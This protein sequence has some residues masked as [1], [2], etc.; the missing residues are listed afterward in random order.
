VYVIAAL[1]KVI[2]R[3]M[4][5]LSLAIVSQPSFLLKETNPSFTALVNYYDCNYGD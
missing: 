3:G 1:L 4:G 2:D 5:I